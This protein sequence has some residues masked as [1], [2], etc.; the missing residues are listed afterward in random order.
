MVAY[1][2]M[3]RAESVG[4]RP[5]NMQAGGSCDTRMFGWITSFFHEMANR[6][7]YDDEDVVVRLFLCVGRS[8]AACAVMRAG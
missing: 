4:T 1:E 2:G 6:D 3:S 7:V 5:E 8:R